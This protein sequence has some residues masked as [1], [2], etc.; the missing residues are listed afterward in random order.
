MENEFSEMMNRLSEDARF[1][2]QKA[3][4]FS[5]KYNNGYNIGSKKRCSLYERHL[6]KH[7]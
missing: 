2:L 5:K 1:A 7:C 6:V 3:D 4:L